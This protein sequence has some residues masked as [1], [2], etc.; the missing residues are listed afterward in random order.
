MNTASQLSFDQESGILSI[1][2]QEM[3]FKK[4][5][6]LDSGYYGKHEAITTPQHPIS[7]AGVHQDSEYSQL[8]NAVLD[9]RLVIEE[10]T[11]TKISKPLIPQ[12]HLKISALRD[13]F[14]KHMVNEKVWTD[15]KGR[16]SKGNHSDIC[17]F[18]DIVG[19]KDI[20]F[21]TPDDCYR[22]QDKLLHWPKHFKKDRHKCVD[23]YIANNPD[24]EVISLRQRERKNNSVWQ[25]FD[26]C[27]NGPLK[28]LSGEN[29]ISKLQLS[30]AFKKE[31]DEVE[32]K[33]SVYRGRFNINLFS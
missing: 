26:W 17:I 4:T 12:E 27:K 11:N 25:L 22:F 1:N 19:D 5:A 15:A 28:Y 2:G 32:K 20:N 16:I 6:F 31:E 24:Y 18:I 23:N 10:L 9:L 33:T 30:T 29:P 13:R 7:T 14:I 8:L 21:V 3:N